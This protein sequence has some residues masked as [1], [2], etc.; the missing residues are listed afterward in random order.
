[1]TKIPNAP[2]LTADFSPRGGGIDFLGLRWVN[3]TII[4]RDLLPELNN[5]TSDMGTFFLGAWIPWKFRQLCSER[6]YTEK[7]YKTFREKVEVALSLTLR[8]DSQIRR[9]YGPVRNRIGITQRCALPGKLSFKN[10]KRTDQNSL[11]AAA[12]YGPSLR[13]LGLIKAYHSQARDGRESLSIPIAGDD[14]DAVAI[15]IGVDDSLKATASYRLLASLESPQFDLEDIRRLGDHGLDPARYRSPEFNSLKASFRCKLLPKDRND[16]GYARTLTTRLVLA[17]VAQ[18]H[19][20]S[21][22][23]MRRAWYTGMFDDGREL[24]LNEAQ[25]TD[26]CR[27]WSCFMA[28]QYQRYG[29]ELFLWCFEVALKAGARSVDEIITHWSDRVVRSGAE[30]GGSFRGLLK[31][32]A[33]SL[34][35]KDEIATSQAWNAEVHGGDERFEHIAEP[36]DDEAVLHGLQ[37]LAG[38]YWRMLLRLQDSKTKEL[39]NLGGSDRMSM[40]WFLKWLQERQDRPMRELLKDIFSDLVFAQHI[41]IALARF[42]GTAQRLRFLLGDSGIEPTLSALSDLAKRSLPWM[43]DRLDT[44][45]ALL[46]DCD[47]LTMQSEGLH[48]GSRAHDVGGGRVADE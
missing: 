6:A 9:D 38:W 12:I 35:E 16:P 29:I 26:H 7:N 14:T 37:M 47:V 22:V 28:R 42:D 30:L 10:A 40:A 46:C 18:R 3:L 33:G 27:H 43:R 21:S 5:V 4:G 19:G 39:M 23:E 44:L 24:S 17:T 41:R 36:Q 31:G 34:F 11:Y 2:F 32:C 45:I 20:L 25:L 48:L 13:A 8:E 15:A 1:M